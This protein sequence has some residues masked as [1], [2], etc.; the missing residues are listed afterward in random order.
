MER[1]LLAGLILFFQIPVWAQTDTVVYPGK[2]Q[3]YCNPRLEG[4]GPSKGVVISYQR[5]CN[6]G[7]T[8][9]SQDTS[10]IESAK[11]TILRN[12]I[13]TFK[14][15]F[16]VWNRS[17]FKLLTGVL[18]QYQEYIFDSSATDYP[19]YQ[20]LQQKHLKS[21]GIYL[22]VLKS[23]NERQYIAGQVQVALNGDYS[24]EMLPNSKYLKFSFAGLYGIKTCATKTYGI[25]LYYNYTFGRQTFLPTI[26]YNNTFNR[27]WGVEI[28]LPSQAKLRYNINMQTLFYFGADVHGAA[29]NLTFNNPPLKGLPNLQLRRSV[30]QFDLEFDREIYD[31]LWFGITGGIMQPISFNLAQ[32][33]SRGVRLSFHKGISIKRSQSLV[34]NSA[35]A[36]PFI[37][38]MLFLVPPRKWANKIL[39]DNR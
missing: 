34:R 6:I 8:S 35:T 10:L 24:S 27:H 36:A 12:N 5:A 11:G 16:P 31:F 13:F 32:Q 23:L 33:N 14:A 37:Q 39:N 28:L 4:M 25:G 19:L 18:Y 9:N 15:K 7:V 2:S 17:S 29:Y 30:V 26:L 20:N 22:D 3:S 38:A 1:F 21:I